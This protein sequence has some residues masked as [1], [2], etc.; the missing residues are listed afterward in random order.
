M[1]EKKR[2]MT[3]TQKEIVKKR[4]WDYNFTEEEFM[5]VQRQTK[6]PAPLP[7]VNMLPWQI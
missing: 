7:N 3:Q 6:F 4:L 1:N 5:G 2:I